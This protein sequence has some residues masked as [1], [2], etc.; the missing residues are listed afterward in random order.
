VEDTHEDL[1]RKNGD[2]HEGVA[3]SEHGEDETIRSI[4]VLVDCG[5]GGSAC[6]GCLDGRFELVKL[7]FEAGKYA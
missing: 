6:L 1:R 7:A 3:A 4:G 5:K 2:W